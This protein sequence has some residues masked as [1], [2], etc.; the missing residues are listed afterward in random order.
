MYFVGQDVPAW[1]VSVEKHM[2]AE[3]YN[4]WVESL[5]EQANSQELDGMKNVG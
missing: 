5:L 1:Q 4:V 2:A 3:D